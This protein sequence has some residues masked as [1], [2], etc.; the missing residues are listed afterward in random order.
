MRIRTVLPS[1]VLVG[2][3]VF[4][5]T[6]CEAGVEKKDNGAASQSGSNTGAAAGASAGNSAGSVAGSAAGAS[7]GAGSGAST[8]A[9]AGAG[10]PATPTG[11]GKSTTATGDTTAGGGSGTGK[12]KSGTT[13]KPTGTGTIS[14]TADGD[15][16]TTDCTGRDVSIVASTVSMS[17]VGTCKSLTVIGND[18]SIETGWFDTITVTGSDNLVLYGVKGD[19]TAPTVKD[20]GTSNQ[21]HSK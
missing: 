8:G 11:A 4:G 21:L 12:P 3:V 1:A 14:I 6:A 5:A 16:P 15:Q 19:G 10:T 17:F 20:T 7:A 18:S 9:S 13:V 2:A